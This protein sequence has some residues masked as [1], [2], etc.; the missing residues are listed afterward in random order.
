MRP[1]PRPLD[2]RSTAFKD[3]PRPLWRALHDGPGVVVTRQPLLGRVALAV[4]HGEASAVLKDTARFTVDARQLGHRTSAG[5]RWWVP[6]MFGPLADNM[7][8]RDGDDHR[9]LRARVDTVF[10]RSRLASLQPRIE[11][12]SAAAVERLVRSADGDFV[13]HVARPVPQQVI[14]ELLGLGTTGG[15]TVDERDRAGRVGRTGGSGRA[16][17]PLDRALSAL[18]NVHGPLDLFRAIPAIRVISTIIRAEI[19]A[20]RR[21]PRDD[22]LSDLVATGGTGRPLKDDEL[23]AMVF[24]LYVAGHETTTHLLSGAVLA[25]LR[26]PELQGRPRSMP[27]DVRAMSE[28]LRWL[29]PVQLGKPR[30]VRET[31]ALADVPLQRGDT[32][33]PLIGAANMDPRW[34][35]D[36]Y[37]LDLERPAGR[38]LGFG[39]G[40]HVCLGLQLAL[41]EGMTTLNTLFERCPDVA[42]QTPSAVP[43]WSRRLGLRALTRLPLENLAPS[44]RA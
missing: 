36:S 22:L 28:L 23:L 5:L 30:F 2:L 10:H 34:A 4:H 37:A 19:D 41:R 25:M 3:D 31:T 29:S 26:E 7:L 20:R 24:L 9:A 40:P 35:S 18:A 14:S 6:G 12:L 42:L 21:E 16:D 17:V 43:A 13:R 33:A 38:H 15:A 1:R 11:A 8:T 27:L 32:I 44:R 39:A